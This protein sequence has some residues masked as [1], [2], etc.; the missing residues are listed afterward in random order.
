[1]LNVVALRELGAQVCLSSLPC[2]RSHNITH[3]H[4]AVP[5]NLLLVVT[6]LMHRQ[7]G[8]HTWGLGSPL[9]WDD[10]VVKKAVERQKLHVSA[11]ACNSLR[12]SC[13]SLDLVSMLLL[14]APLIHER[15]PLLQI[16]TSI[17]EASR[18]LMVHC[19]WVVG[20]ELVHLELREAAT[21]L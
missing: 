4:Q 14:G 11:E 1:M 2:S 5:L 20:G 6:N 12:S 7:Q 16:G 18:F 10:A 8:L 15:G 21:L 17:Q 9:L 13:I 19:P 3:H